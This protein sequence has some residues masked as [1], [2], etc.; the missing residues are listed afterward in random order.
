MG[1]DCCDVVNWR[2]AVQA[3][4]NQPETE[5]VGGDDAHVVR[6]C[7]KV[8]DQ[9]AAEAGRGNAKNWLVTDRGPSFELTDACLGATNANERSGH[10]HRDTHTGS[11]P[12]QIA[13]KRTHDVQRSKS[14][15]AWR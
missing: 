14:I 6:P 10:N 15:G 4:P 13:R 9:G 2:S 1:G 5:R 7:R 8:F 11:G 3:R 12:G